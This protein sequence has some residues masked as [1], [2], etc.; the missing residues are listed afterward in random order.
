MPVYKMVTLTI[1]ESS[2]KS[3][4]PHGLTIWITVIAA[5]KVVRENIVPIHPK[6]MVG[7]LGLEQVMNKMD[8]L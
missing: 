1:T 7:R 8:R 6:D 5:M 3:P 2:E 4:W